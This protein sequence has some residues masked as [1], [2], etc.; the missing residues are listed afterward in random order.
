MRTHHAI[1]IGRDA[2]EED[3]AAQFFQAG[4]HIPIRWALLQEKIEVC[5]I[6]RLPDNGSKSL[7]VFV[8]SGSGAVLTRRGRENRVSGVGT[9]PA[10]RSRDGDKS[11]GMTLV[12][13]P[14]S[15]R[16]S[17]DRFTYR[18]SCVSYSTILLYRASLLKYWSGFGRL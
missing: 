11:R 18:V 13:L 10:P 15:T 12:T 14:R 8:R 16:S 5:H 7:D 3:N 2:I 6:G 9:P 17:F 1:V 4:H